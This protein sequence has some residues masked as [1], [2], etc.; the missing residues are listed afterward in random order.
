LP[1]ASVACY[2]GPAGTEGIGICKSGTKTCNAQGTLWLS[3]VGQVLPA[4]DVCSTAADDDCN[5]S[6]MPCVTS[7]IWSKSYT[8]PDPYYQWAVSRVA[9]DGAGNVYALGTGV[10][11][12]KLDGNGNVLWTKNF[13]AGVGDLVV[14]A[15]GNIL[16]TGSYT[17]TPDLGGGPLPSPAFMSGGAF[18]AKFD[19]AGG[20]VWSK[21]FPPSNGATSG[22]VI[23][24]DLAGN[25][26]IGGSTTGCIN[27]GSGNLCPS[28][29]GGDLFI[30]KLDATGTPLW[31]KIGGGT[32]NGGVQ[33]V[34]MDAQGNIAL[35]GWYSDTLDLGSGTFTAGGPTFVAKLDSAGTPIFVKPIGGGGAAPISIVFDSA[36]NELT[37]GSAGAFDIGGGP[38]TSGGFVGKLDPNGNHLWSHDIGNGQLQ[39]IYGLSADPSDNLLV[40]GDFTGIIAVGGTFLQSAGADDIFVAKYDTAGTGLAAERYG[41]AAWLQQG[42]CVAVDAAGA[43]YLSGSFAGQ[44]D[45]GSGTLI[46]AGASDGFLAKL[47]PW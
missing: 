47:P 14:D 46:A 40:T 33:S 13:D 2:D 36:G 34:V 12:L 8:S 26:V 1:N 37:A 18:V 25:V 39:Y 22:G 7:S 16:V 29:Y 42:Y 17:G 6:P 41:D 5:G 21:G 20:H 9:I 32:N 3:C 28:G 45:F 23:A 4:P 11:I 24:V 30:A 27:L 35:A 10:S 38:L 31:S 19:A 43:R 15:G 44:V